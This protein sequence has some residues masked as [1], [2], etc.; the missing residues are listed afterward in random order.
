MTTRDLDLETFVLHYEWYTTRYNETAKELL[1]F[2]NLQVHDGRELTPFSPGKVYPYFTAEEKK[3]VKKAFQ[4]M[5]SPRTWEHIKHYFENI[6]EKEETQKNRN[7][8]DSLDKTRNQSRPPLDSLVQTGSKTEITGDVQFLMDF[9][10]VGYPKT[11]TSMMVRWLSRQTGIQM[12]DHEIY[13]LKDGEPADMVR[14]LYA[15]PEGEQFKR[16][17]K[18]PRDIHNLKAL[19]AFSS[20]WPQTKLIVGLRHPVLWFESF[21]NF[22]TRC[23][24][25]LPLPNNLIGNCPPGAH[26]VCTEEIRYHDHLSLLGMT[27]RSDPGELQLLSPVSPMNRDSPK[28]KNPI[29]L[30]EIGQLHDADPIRTAQYRE[31]LKNYLGLRTPI[32]ELTESKESHSEHPNKNKE[33]DICSP[34]L[35][36]VH[37]ELM[38]IARDASIWIR[39][40]FLNLPNVFVSSPDHFNKLLLDWLVDPCEKRRYRAT[41]RP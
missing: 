19:E 4:L 39:E 22:R 7:E 38:K 8:L 1:Q 10:I 30:Y 29:F 36:N 11:A 35:E 26:N 31:D 5:A 21:Y 33:I 14:K 41:S 12:Y 34:D 28:L 6:E 2:L 27:G 15:L 25:D 13:H 16:G 32:D 20:F 24:F 23:N 18:A 17:Y 3:A 37:D 9:A 40:Y